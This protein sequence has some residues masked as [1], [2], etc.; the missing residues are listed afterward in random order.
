MKHALIPLALASAPAFAA[1]GDILHL[2]V[3]SL[4][5][6]LPD[7]RDAG[8][9]AALSLADDRLLALVEEFGDRDAAALLGEFL[10]LMGHPME[11]RF[12]MEGEFDPNMGPPI[13]LDL[14]VSELPAE[15]APRVHG[16]LIRL[17]TEEAGMVPEPMAG[18][19]GWVGVPTPAGMLS[20]GPG[21]AT[22][23]GTFGVRFGEVPPVDPAHAA[24][25]AFFA[26]FDLEGQQMLLEMM[27]QG[28]G[29]DAEELR[30]ILSIL[31]LD[32][33]HPLGAEMSM[34]YENG[35]SLG[36]ATIH[37]YVQLSE[38]MGTLVSEPLAA[39][40]LAIIPQDATWASI[41]RSNLSGVLSIVEMMPDGEMMLE[42]LI[43][44]MHRETGV[45]LQND[46]LGNL[47]TVSGAYT[48]DSTGG[49]GLLSM[50]MFVE[51]SNAEG[52]LGGLERIESLIDQIGQTEAEGYVRIRHYEEGDARCASL[53]FPGLPVPIEPSWA[54]HGNW[55]FAAASP[56]ALSGAL[57]QSGGSGPGLLANAGFRA[58]GG[59]RA[60]DCISVQ[61]Q[62][63][64]RFVSEGY[65]MA[66]MAMAAIAN[67][68][69]S[70]Q[71]PSVDPG[72]VMPPFADVV[73]G[74][75]PSLTLGRIAGDDMVMES[76][77]DASWTVNI[78]AMLGSPI[79][80]FLPAMMAIGAGTGF[81]TA[82]AAPMMGG[83]YDYNAYE[84]GYV[85]G[86]TQIEMVEPISPQNEW[87][88]D[89]LRTIKNAID[90]YR[91][92]N[93]GR[94]PSELGALS[95]PD[96]N[97]ARFLSE[98]PDDPWGRSYEYLPPDPQETVG[99]LW[100]YSLGADGQPGG[101]GEDADV[102]FG[103]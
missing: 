15:V 96:A 68:V 85:D 9:R 63:T 27:M 103:G 33:E 54:V 34:R 83:Y 69:R 43:N 49:G 74:A 102:F 22:S 101:V 86:P 31:G 48:A 5:R 78:S 91:V 71:D 20:F 29:P 37:N 13:Y 21:A 42:E 8:L 73:G 75:Q 14:Q 64:A 92:Q 51:L 79:G 52:M 65:G 12:G 90:Q 87:I 56:Q 24:E 89:D 28:M 26:R 98:V 17:F 46:I 39:E 38:R 10:P 3:D 84:L 25:G 55:L 18:Q 60:A 44:E 53:T 30:P 76:W 88:Q 19:A 16:S 41:S 57:A 45:H 62:D 72:L 61:Y 4:E 2:R 97:G 80:A 67:A 36:R 82:R 95:T 77:S 23:G 66:N 47:G 94:Y 70:P 7:A 100:L 40:H 81:M 1:P 93:A 11:L 32:G 50:V 99:E 59:E 58:A 35:R 6:L